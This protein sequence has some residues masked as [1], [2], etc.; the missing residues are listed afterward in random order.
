[1]LATADA[2]EEVTFADLADMPI[3]YAAPAL[4]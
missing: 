1:L 3:T 4:A 2:W